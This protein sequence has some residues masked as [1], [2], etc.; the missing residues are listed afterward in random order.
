MAILFGSDNY[1]YDFHIR[2]LEQAFRQ[3]LMQTIVVVAMLS[4]LLTTAIGI[5][6]LWLTGSFAVPSEPRSIQVAAAMP[7]AER[8]TGPRA[9]KL[10]G[11][12]AAAN[13]SSL[14]QNFETRPVSLAPS[15]PEGG[16]VESQSKPNG[17]GRGSAIANTADMPGAER[18]AEPATARS[19]RLTQAGGGGATDETREFIQRARS[20][21]V[22]GDI[23]TAR[24]FLE[25]AADLGDSSAT[26]A[27]AETYDPIILSLWPARSLLADGDRARVLYEE[28]LASGVTEAKQRM[29][30]LTATSS[31]MR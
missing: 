23:K 30:R 29:D 14:F 26:F 8:P 27:L 2:Q 17:D 18:L 1:P 16:L 4:T 19:P 31:A 22:Q 11:C 25:R 12:F 21:L 7:D 20:F 15:V 10:Y 28:A 13:C 5:G 3:R 6:L 9:E 24:L